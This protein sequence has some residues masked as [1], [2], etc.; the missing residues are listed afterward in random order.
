[1]Y[2]AGKMADEAKSKEGCA[3][4][5]EIISPEAF[6]ISTEA[7]GK[8]R[9]T[10]AF[11]F[12]FEK[13][14]DPILLL[15][16]DKFIDCNEAA[17]TRLRCSDKSGIVGLHPSN[18][19]P[20][21]Q[22]DGCSS[23]KKAQEN[24]QLAM[25][26][27]SGHLEWVHRDFTGKEFWVD[28]SLSVMPVDRQK[29]ICVIWRDISN[30][31][32]AKGKP[33]MS[34]KTLSDIVEFL[35]DGTFVIDREKKV[36]AWNRALEVVTG[37]K[38]EEMLG[39]GDYAYAVPFYGEPRPM[40]IDLVF[41]Q[42]K[43][44]GKRYNSF[45]REGHTVFGEAYLSA[46]YGGKGAYFWGAVSPLFDEAGGIIGA[47]ESI[48]DITENKRIQ[49]ELE[50][51]KKRYQKVVELSPSAILIHVDGRIEFVNSAFVQMMRAK[52][53]EDL[54]GRCILDF[55]H[56]DYRDAVRVT[57][58][59]EK[60]QGEIAERKIVRLD[61]CAIDVEGRFFPFAYHGRNGLMV[62]VEDITERKRTVEALNRRE[63]EL[64]DKTR[65]LEEANA[66]LK[67]VLRTMEEEKTILQNRMAAN[68]TQFVTPHIEKL[69]SRALSEDQKIHLDMIE[70]N[71]NEIMSPFLQQLVAK[72]PLTPMEIQVLN[73]IK[74]GRTSKVIAQ[75]LSISKGT[76]DGH[77]NNIRR[78]LGLQN[79]NINLQ[80]YLL[81][82]FRH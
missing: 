29:I 32:Q 6:S 45:R 55:V 30:R 76:V 54:Q 58:D 39:K 12:L 47:I 36:I 5:K 43:T 20:E 52:N 65:F 22:P 67:V 18:I 78:K 74:S 14:S 27:G 64:A 19:S 75:L 23:L 31:K 42:D 2:G 49:K 11:R 72:Y 56:P 4:E 7:R 35:P 48:R 16:R 34:R 53:R 38:K 77:R 3:H 46:V 63:Q 13:S 69:R 79:K 71:I 21:W 80:R 62:V 81:S 15:N 8:D 1:M 73:M 17:L 70:S 82:S 41:E 10:D 37:V 59:V 24:L 68:I 28:V 60:R 44:I 25:E 50:E 51:A 57:M 33:M 66:A 9:E 40:A 26:K 61:G